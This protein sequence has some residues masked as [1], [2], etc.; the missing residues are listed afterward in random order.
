MEVTSVGSL[1]GELPTE[2]IL[3]LEPDLV[4]APEIISPEQIQI[5]EDLGLKVYFQA[6]PVDFGGLWENLRILGSITGHEAEATAL[7]AEL[8]ERIL[9]VE[10]KVDNISDRPSVFYE[11][12]ATDP[13]NPYTIG[14]GTFIDT[15]INMAG[16]TNIGAVLDGD[17]AQISSEEVIAQNPDII[18]LADAPYGITPESVANRAGWEG[19]SAVL[20]D[21]VF[22][23]DPFLVSVPGPRLV[24][25][26]ETM[27]VLLHPEVFK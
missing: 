24:K 16:G 12:D 13:Q 9:N 22:P 21:Q 8:E 11:L 20:N 26:L 19:I 2:A 3:A 17:Y 4:L 6:N 10:G 27:A 15:I 1:W 7:I 18:L 5:M 14:S 23:F 25:G